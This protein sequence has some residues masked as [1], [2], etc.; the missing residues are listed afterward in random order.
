[1]SLTVRA[2]RPSFLLPPEGSHIAR[3]YMVVDLGLQMS[4]KYGT[5]EEKILIGWELDQ[6]TP[7]A[8][9]IHLQAFTARLDRG[10]KLLQLLEGWYNKRFT[11]EECNAFRLSALIDQSCYLTLKHAPD[12]RDPFKQWAHVAHAAPL[13]QGVVYQ[14]PVHPTVHF[15]FDSYS[16]ANFLALPEKIRSKINKNDLKKAAQ[17]LA[18]TVCL[19]CSKTLRI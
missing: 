2:T 17:Q 3:C 13:P 1:M 15:D 5:A 18:S 9:L 7:S 4:K 12:Y 19:L 14:N 6:G 10:T 11:E 16:E 8:P